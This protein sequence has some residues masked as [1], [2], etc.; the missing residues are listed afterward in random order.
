M[1]KS[2]LDHLIE[3]IVDR[4]CENKCT[5]E[6]DNLL[7]TITE[8]QHYYF[9][10]ALL[11]SAETNNVK[12]YKHIINNHINRIDDYYIDASF[13]SASAF[14]NIIV[15]K[16]ITKN[17]SHKISNDRINQCFIESIYRNSKDIS[18]YI[19]SKYTSRI[20]DFS[21][22]FILKHLD[23]YEPDIIKMINIIYSIRKYNI[24]TY[25]NILF[26]G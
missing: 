2:T 11:L 13:Q 16:Y 22:D 14:G 18:L 26:I 15:L 24:N 19:L 5:E 3:I 4:G 17:L 9:N 12:I 8:Y 21:I 23:A 6:I 25:A 7:E 1:F 10:K 20:T